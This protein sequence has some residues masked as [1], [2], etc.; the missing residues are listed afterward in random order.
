[1]LCL[2]EKVEDISKCKA[3]NIGNYVINGNIEFD[4][5]DKI[6]SELGLF[7]TDIANWNRNVDNSIFSL[8]VLV[9]FSKIG[10]IIYN[11]LSKHGLKM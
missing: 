9:D 2:C 10:N 7:L 1:M 6:L 5:F 3:Q 4:D 8:V 11:I